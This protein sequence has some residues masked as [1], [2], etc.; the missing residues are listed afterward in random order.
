MKI[1]VINDLHL[2]PEGELV[3]GQDTNKAFECGWR[4]IA[5]LVECA[6]LVV[7]NGDVAHNAS[8]EG[9]RRFRRATQ[10]IKSKLMVTVGNHDDRERLAIELGAA[11]LDNTGY[12][13]AAHHAA[14]S[15]VLLDTL[16]PGRPEGALCAVRLAWL[17]EQLDLAAERPVI[18]IM[19]HPPLNLGVDALDEVALLD[20]CDALLELLSRRS[21]PVTLLAGHH[22]ISA[23]GRIGP[24]SYCICPAFSGPPA[25]FGLWGHA[26]NFGPGANGAC[27]LTVRQDG[28]VD[29]RT[30]MC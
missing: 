8:V 16:V 6:D 15:V 17:R 22:H 3:R 27:A 1:I 4:E 19:H 30:V 29:V 21:A 2:V 11:H 23:S 9:Y 7:V 10:E 14:A 25:R 24:I 18:A 26:P 28:R 13:Q 12:V 5:P 20:G